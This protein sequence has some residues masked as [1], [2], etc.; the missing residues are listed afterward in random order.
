MFNSYLKLTWMQIK[1]FGREPVALFFTLIFPLL[2]LLLFGAIF[3][4]EPDPLYGGFGYIDAQVP[5]ITALI[6][7][8]IGLLSIPV[9]TA[10]AREQKVLRRYK[11]TPMRPSLYIL[12]DITMQVLSGLIGMAILAIAAYFVFD[13]RF[14]GNWFTVFLGFL[15]SMCSFSAVGYVIAGLS[16]TGRIAQVV[17]Q[18]FYLP[19]MFLS[20]ATMP[21]EIMGEGLRTFSNLLPMTHVVIL[22]RDLWFGTGWNTTAV[23]VLTSMMFIGA[24]VSSYTFRWE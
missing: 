16:T 15:L 20:G 23:L 9:A 14:G 8:T 4:N 19:M 1:L 18:V 7:G 12:A 2:L 6:I 22:L 24:A 17:G 11:A 3:G 21:L 5:G 13:V 10:T